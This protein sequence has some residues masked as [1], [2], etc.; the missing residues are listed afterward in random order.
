VSDAARPTEPT[1]TLAVEV[2]REPVPRDTPAPVDAD[3]L[4]GTS[5]PAPTG[6]TLFL[7]WDRERYSGAVPRRIP[8]PADDPGPAWLAFPHARYVLCAKHASGRIQ[9]VYVTSLLGRRDSLFPAG[10]VERIV[11]DDRSVTVVANGKPFLYAVDAGTTVDL[12]A[13]KVLGAA[14]T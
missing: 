2:P 10:D 8:L 5:S 7:D 4:A 14:Q 11:T 12:T 9:Q 1:H 3:G 6:P 13:R